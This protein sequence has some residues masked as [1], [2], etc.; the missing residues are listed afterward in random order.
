MAS[1]NPTAGLTIGVIPLT[2]S[3]GVTILAGEWYSYLWDFGDGQTSTLRNPE[4]TYNTT[5]YHTVVVTAYGDGGASTSVMR[6]AWVRVGQMSFV[7]EYDLEGTPPV[8]ASFT[9]TSSAPTGYELYDWDWDFGDASLHSGA[10]G[11]S[12]VYGDYG[13]YNVQLDAKLRSL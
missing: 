12:H 4:H 8:S 2:V 5:G 1:I 11:P 13:N 7:S 10:T 6:K 3:F 9:N